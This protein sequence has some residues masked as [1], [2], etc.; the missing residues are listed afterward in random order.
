MPVRDLAGATPTAAPDPAQVVLEVEGAAWTVRVLGR[1]G[2]APGMSAPL[3]LLGFWDGDADPRRPPSREALVVARALEDL[4]SGALE[5]ALAAA[6]PPRDPDKAP[7]FF[8][9]SGQGPRRRRANENI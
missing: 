6:R 4:S 2:R 9:E 5:E 1:A 3:L 8:Q 7:G